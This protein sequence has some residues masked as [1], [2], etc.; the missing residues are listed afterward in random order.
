MKTKK[1]PTT[2]NFLKK[3][4]PAATVYHFWNIV[5]T[6]IGIDEKSKPFKNWEKSK[7]NNSG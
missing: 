7:S 6:E 5:K 2:L 1:Q 3:I 4:H